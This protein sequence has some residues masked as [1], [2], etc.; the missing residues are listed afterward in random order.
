[1]S[2]SAVYLYYV[3]SYI[4]VFF[5]YNVLSTCA[6]LWSRFKSHY[7]SI[8]TIKAFTSLPNLTHG[9]LWEFIL[10]LC[11]IVCFTVFQL[12]YSQYRIKNMKLFNSLTD[13]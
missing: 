6:P 10:K 4:I 8:M 13:V 11:N 9:A 12:F 7:T 1:M 5:F 2:P 3:Y